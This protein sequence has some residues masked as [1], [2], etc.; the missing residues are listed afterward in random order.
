MRLGVT[1]GM[2]GATCTMGSGSSANVDGGS[3]WRGAQ[4]WEVP[5]PVATASTLVAGDSA[6]GAGC[7]AVL[8]GFRSLESDLPD[9]PI[10]LDTPPC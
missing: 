6:V 8:K 1:D 7:D 5:A 10:D 9:A 2:P 3:A 4:A